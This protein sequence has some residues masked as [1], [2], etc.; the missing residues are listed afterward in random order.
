MA[1]SRLR[2]VICVA[3]YTKHISYYDDWMDA[4][5]KSD[6]FEAEVVNI[7]APGAYDDLKRKQR[8]ADGIILLHSTNGD[9]LE[10]MVPLVG[11]LSERKCPLLSFVGNEFNFPGAY[12]S[13]KRDLFKKFE[14]DFIATQLLQEAGSFLFSDVVKQK[15]YSVPHALN[16]DVFQFKTAHKD[17]VWDLGGRAVTYLPHLGD[18]ERN[19][20]HDF[21]SAHSF[22]PDLKVDI[23]NDRFDRAGW[24]DYLNSCRGTVSSEA[25]SWYLERDDRTV[26]AIEEWIKTVKTGAST[27]RSDGV[28]ARLAQ[29]LPYGLKQTI[30]SLMKFGPIQYE[31]AVKEELNFQ[32][33]YDLFFEDTPKAPVYSKCISSRHFDAIGTGTCQIL[34]EGRYNDI[35][36]PHVHYIPLKADYSNLDEV[37]EIF[38]S[39]ESEKIAQNVSDYVR[40]NHTYVHRAQTVYDILTSA[41]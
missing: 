37:L 2:V 23:S 26:K 21:F 18:R 1:G 7:M 3:V 16:S 22:D 17:R 27:I 24:A 5:C 38:H 39:A 8:E 29:K 33:V 9:T 31:S 4:F 32:E 19:E 20:L 34:L 13:E 6:L 36:I 12:I 40:E 11:L 25:G 41:Q 14:P 10:Y 35:L 30:R 15:V 28:I